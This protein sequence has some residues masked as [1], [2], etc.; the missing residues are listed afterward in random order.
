MPMTERD[1]TEAVQNGHDKSAQTPGCWNCP[2]YFPFAANPNGGTCRRRAP[3][4]VMV[5]VK[6]LLVGQEPQP[7]VPGYFPI[8]S[9]NV[10]CGEHPRWP[11]YLD[12]RNAKMAEMAAAKAA[13][14]A[15][16]GGDAPA[17]EGAPEKFH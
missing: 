14:G 15:E 6:A 1:E 5:G 2:Y 13:A 7:N 17:A 9:L 11:D 10:I 8:T 4:P 3:L 16:T 12:M